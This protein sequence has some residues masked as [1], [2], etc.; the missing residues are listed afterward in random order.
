MGTNY[1]GKGESCYWLGEVLLYSDAIEIACFLPEYPLKVMSGF[2]SPTPSKS[3][4]SLHE[5]ETTPHNLHRLSL[6][7]WVCFLHIVGGP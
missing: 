4:A 6:S 7:G 3:S 5:H 1:L 2:I